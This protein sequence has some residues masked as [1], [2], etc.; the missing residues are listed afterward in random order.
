MKKINVDGIVY[1]PESE[2]NKLSEKLENMD[3]VLVRTNSAGVFFGYMEQKVGKEIVLLKARRVWYWEGAASL[4]QLAQ[5]GTSKPE[6]CKFP[7]AVE[8]VILTDVIEID[9]I[10]EKS[11]LILNSVPIWRQ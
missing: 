10:T 8:K 9:Y 2:C 4:S 3:F 5:E 6:K 1:I 7:I 11:K